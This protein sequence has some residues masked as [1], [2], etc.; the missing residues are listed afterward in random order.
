LLVALR[1]QKRGQASG[2]VSWRLTQLVRQADAKVFK[3]CSQMKLLMKRQALQ[4]INRVKNE[5]GVL[6]QAG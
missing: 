3:K 5:V 2:R 6:R 4:K 1:P